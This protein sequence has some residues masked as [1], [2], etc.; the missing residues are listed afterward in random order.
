M[1]AADGDAEA[2]IA[3][4]AS[5]SG[6]WPGVLMF[7]DAIGLR[8]RLQ[9][10]AQELADEGYVVLAPNLFY[11]AASVADIAPTAPLDT[12]EAREAH[13][14]KLRPLMSGLTSA[15]STADTAVWLDA[16]RSRDDVADGPVGVVGFCMG[17]RLALRAAGAHPDLV[18]AVAGFHGGGLVTDDADSPHRAIASATAEFVLGG[19]DHDDSL[20]PAAVQTLSDEFERA[21]LVADNTIYPDA[22]HGFTMADTAAYQQAG[23]Q[24]A[25]AATVDLLGRTLR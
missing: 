2:I 13:F 17:V 6:P 16:L 14:G 24:R 5:G 18:K 12:P 1:P 11:R 4:P 22:P 23:A 19:A 9:D 15:Q 21:G 10:M 7:M 8:P 20:P 3:T 25:F